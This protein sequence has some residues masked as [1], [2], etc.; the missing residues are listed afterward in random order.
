MTHPTVYRIPFNDPRPSDKLTADAMHNL[1]M[2]LMD[3][4]WAANGSYTRA[5]NRIMRNQC[6]GANAFLTHTCTAALE[7]CVLLTELSP[8]D[9]VIMPSWTFA[10]TANAVILH[11]GVPVFVDVDPATM[12]ITADLI[13]EALTSK[14]KAVIVVHYAGLSCDMD[15]IL[16]LCNNHGLFIIEDAAQAYGSTYKGK[17]VGVLGDFGAFSFHATKNLTCGEGGAFATSS[18]IYFQSAEIARDKGTNRAAFL[19]G[20][21]DNYTWQS[22]GYAAAPS[23]FSAAIL[24]PQ[25]LRERDI[26]LERLR[27]WDVYNACLTRC[28]KDSDGH[29]GHIFWLKLL[30]NRSE[31]FINAMATE[32]S[33]QISRHFQP[34]HSSPMGLRFGR[35]HGNMHATDNAAETLVRFPLYQRLTVDQ[36]RLIAET[37]NHIIKR[38]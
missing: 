20:L 17:P 6:A 33:I 10:S 29:N 37:A 5:C 36:A 18:P 3:K 7:L 1:N 19:R 9:E 8:G 12:N 22:P 25:L 14:T 28:S 26:T 34:L 4:D 15:P 11:K 31:R 13:Q 35:A 27:C 16:E 30:G 21:A 23:E 32:G 2:I 38:L 24:L